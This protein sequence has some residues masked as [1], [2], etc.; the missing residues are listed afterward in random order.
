MAQV[1][2]PEIYEFWPRKDFNDDLNYKGV[3]VEVLVVESIFPIAPS[4]RKP[5]RRK[6]ALLELSR[7]HIV[8]GDSFLVNLVLVD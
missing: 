2:R 1:K 4:V 3:V 7:I 5:L 8:S 6:L